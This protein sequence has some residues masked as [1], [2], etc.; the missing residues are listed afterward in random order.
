M[1]MIEIQHVSNGTA[2]TSKSLRIAP[3]VLK[4]AKWSLSAVRPAPGNQR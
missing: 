3:P 1:A 2:K 4:K